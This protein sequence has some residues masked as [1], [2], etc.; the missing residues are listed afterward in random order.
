MRRCG[1]C[2]RGGAVWRM[3]S[4]IDPGVSTCPEIGVVAAASSSQISQPL[5]MVRIFE[6]AI[7]PAVNC[8]AIVVTSPRYWTPSVAFPDVLVRA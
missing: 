3:E 5:W 1:W 2:D 4:S 8:L 7:R 6:H